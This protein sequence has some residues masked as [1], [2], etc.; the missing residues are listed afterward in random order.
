MKDII[1][2]GLATK[3]IAAAINR[4]VFEIIIES[5]WH[6]FSGQPKIKM[7][8]Q[9]LVSVKG[10]VFCNLID[11]NVFSALGNP[12][13]TITVSLKPRM[14]LGALINNG[15]TTI[16]LP[17]NSRYIIYSWDTAGLLIKFESSVKDRLLAIEGGIPF[18]ISSLSTQNPALNLLFSSKP[19]ANF[20]NVLS[21]MDSNNSK[22]KYFIK[23]PR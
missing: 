19:E 12:K 7:I 16:H 4:E 8:E 3:D 15:L 6:S 2:S 18:S 11:P 21:A 1:E 9:S 17:R 20:F 23:I 13:E 22:S 5:D 10:A 14:I